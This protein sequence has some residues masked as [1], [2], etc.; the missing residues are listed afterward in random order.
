MD[1]LFVFCVRFVKVRLSWIFVVEVCMVFERILV[2]VGC[3]IVLLLGSL[4]LVMCGVGSDI[5]IWF[6][7]LCILMLFEVKLIFRKCLIRLSCFRI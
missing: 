6:C 7:G 4:G 3:M 5:S 2:S 1:I